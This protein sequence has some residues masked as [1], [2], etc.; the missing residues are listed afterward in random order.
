[1]PCCPVNISCKKLSKLIQTIADTSTPKAGG[2]NSLTG[3]KSGSVGQTIALNGRIVKSVLGYHEIT[4][5]QTKRKFMAKINASRT[6]EIIFAIAI[7]PS[8]AS[9][10]PGTRHTAAVATESNNICWFRCFWTI[11]EA[12]PSTILICVFLNVSFVCIDEV[13]F[14]WKLL[15][16]LRS[17]N[18]HRAN[19]I[20]D[21]ESDA[22]LFFDSATWKAKIAAAEELGCEIYSRWHVLLLTTGAGMHV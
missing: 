2:T 8:V 18:K 13:G 5:R 12:G 19:I 9:A 1:M 17:D 21:E 16:I 11:G 15:P 20:M 6:G 7:D 22:I 14:S 10:T 4:V 3:T